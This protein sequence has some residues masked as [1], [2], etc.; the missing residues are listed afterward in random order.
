MSTKYRWAALVALVLITLGYG[1]V[2]IA[3]SHLAEGQPIPIARGTGTAIEAEVAADGAVV[4]GGE[5]FADPAE[6]KAKIAEI[7]QRHPDAEFMLRPQAGA[8]FENTAKAVML[9]AHNGANRVWVV[10]EPRA[11]PANK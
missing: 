5:R 1:Y 2:W 7:Q 11:V 8:S 3:R 4:I 6:L 9:F 10:T